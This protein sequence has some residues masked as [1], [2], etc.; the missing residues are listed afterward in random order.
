MVED[1]QLLPVMPEKYDSHAENALL[2]LFHEVATLPTEKNKELPL[3][4]KGEPILDYPYLWEIL[5]S[6]FMNTTGHGEIWYNYRQ[7]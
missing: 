3:A 7:K 1:S 5:P 2:W 6:P 4:R